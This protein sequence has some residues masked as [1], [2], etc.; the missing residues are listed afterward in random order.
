MEKRRTVLH[1]VDYSSCSVIL[2][3]LT[4]GVSDLSSSPDI[5]DRP[6]LSASVSLCSL[7]QLVRHSSGGFQEG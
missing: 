1:L 7:F 2:F 4:N 6:Q 5:D 3:T